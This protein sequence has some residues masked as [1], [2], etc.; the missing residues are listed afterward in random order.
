M[1]G[2]NRSVG[3]NRSVS[4]IR[5]DKVVVFDQDNGRTLGRYYHSESYF[6]HCADVKSG[7]TYEPPPPLLLLNFVTPI[8]YRPW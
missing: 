4:Q 2:F 6:R 5:R 3:L 1:S 8:T 7:S